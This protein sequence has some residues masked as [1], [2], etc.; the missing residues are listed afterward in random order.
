MKIGEIFTMLLVSFLVMYILYQIFKFY[1]IGTDVYAV[2]FVFY[3]FILLSI[4]VLPNKE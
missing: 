2:Y 3:T 1:G 4:L